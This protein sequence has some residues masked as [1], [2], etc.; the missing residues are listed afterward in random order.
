MAEKFKMSCTFEEFVANI[1]K[2][3]EHKRDIKIH[4]KAHKQAIRD[5]KKEGLLPSVDNLDDDE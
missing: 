3:A 1:K 2:V 4:T 5:S